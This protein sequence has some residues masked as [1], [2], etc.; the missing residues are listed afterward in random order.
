MIGEE[1]RARALQPL[2]RIN[3]GLTDWP[4]GFG[5]YAYGLDFHEYLVEQ[6]GPASLGR[7]A[8]ETSRRLPYLTTGAFKQVFR[9]S[10]GTLWKDFEARLL[11]K[12]TP[13]ARD[14]QIARI[15]QHGF[16]AAGPRFD[17]FAGNS[18]VYAARTP[19]GFPALNR[20]R[21]DGAPPDQIVRR[22]FGE[23]TALAADTIYFDQQEYR[24]NVGLYSDLYALSRADHHVTR[25]T[26][27][28][29]LLDPDL[30]PDGSTLVCVQQ[31]LGQRNLALVRLNADTPRVRHRL[32]SEP[33]TQFNAPRW[34]P[35]G[36]TIAVERHRPGELSQVVLVDVETKRIRTLVGMVRRDGH[37]RLAAD[38]RAVADRA[39]AAGGS[40]STCGNT[41][42][43]S[44]APPRQVTHTT[45][46]ATWPD[47]SADGRTIAFVGY[48]VD[49]F[50]VFTMPY[51]PEPVPA[52]QAPLKPTRDHEL[53]TGPRH[54]QRPRH[55][56]RPIRRSRRC[57]RRPGRR[58]SSDGDQGAWA[59][60]SP[61]TTFSP[62][63]TT[64]PPRRG[65]HKV[66]RAP[67][68]GCVDS[69][70]ES[71]LL[72]TAVGGRVLG[73]AR[74]VDVLFRRTRGATGEPLPVT[75]R[76]RQIEG[77]VR[78]P[79]SH[80]RV[81]HLALGSLLRSRDEFT[82]TTA[83]APDP[84]TARRFAAAGARPPRAPMATPS[85]RR[86]DSR[87]WHGG[88][89][90][91]RARLRSG[92]DHADRGCAA[93]RADARRASRAAVRL[94]GGASSGDVNSRRN[95]CSAAPDRIPP[96]STSTATRSACCAAFP[97]TVLPAATR[98][99]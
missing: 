30:S 2:D 27:E 74:V 32:L 12:S 84:A 15:T 35:D 77:G 59:C 87:R 20:V 38:G 47:V 18:L 71:L 82:A 80:A 58:S 39:G 45:G 60:R 76:Q 1:A 95:F 6:F 63:T 79:V 93:L 66:R 70:L 55:R 61:A 97:P 9:E 67:N 56:R 4:S 57:G 88:S 92:C 3:G 64:P 28:A 8:D 19:H 72:R 40:R 96:S 14:P 62:I 24:R 68:T 86:R 78:F 31:K 16:V 36:R 29:R 7:L 25:L 52:A 49:G 34:S 89:R 99:C 41:A 51:P 48:T 21:L 81:S 44:P 22:Y 33:E 69:G 46:G 43:T 5:P 94:A 73:H 42:S 23:T 75:L 13:V 26:H 50:D 11:A 85:A 91:P 10:L 65:S 54:A 90:S 83:R 98:R 53:R 37:A 17:K